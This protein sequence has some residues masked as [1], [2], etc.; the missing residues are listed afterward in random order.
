MNPSAFFPEPADFRIAS[1]AR[2]AELAADFS[3]PVGEYETARAA[4]GLFDRSDRGIAIV[5]GADRATWLH[6]LLSNA[7]KTV[8]VNE[9]VYAFALDVRGRIR[10]DA[11]VLILPDEIWLDLD[12]GALPAALEHL[13]KFLIM[14]KAEITDASL[15]FA[16]LGV[17]GPR[18]G[19]IAT[20]IGAPNFGALP[21]LHGVWIEKGATRLIRHDFAG[22]PGFE[23]IF[24]RGVAARWWSRLAGE[25]NVRPV[26]FDVLD[27]LR[28]E[29][30]IP[31]LG[32]DMDEKTVA[33]ET[34]QIERAISY[35]KGCYLGQEV[36]ERMRSHGSQARRL[37]RLTAED[38]AGIAIPAALY[39]RETDQEVGRVTS[40]VRHPVNRS[41]VGLGYLRS[42]L[43]EP[44][45]LMFGGKP[46][47]TEAP[48][49]S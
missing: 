3:D 29:A 43:Q 24:P 21:A 49:F 47:R 23:L 9:G 27:V 6:N 41:W 39:L 30:G 11:N 26:G 46:I 12:L 22:L 42:G 16:R 32:R 18:A 28:I 14:E 37:V 20:A 35:G 10:F 48:G 19:E 7:V 33:P 45:N 38:A 5:R 2:G 44:I 40:L 4:A 17:S 15:N 13:N 8:D 1:L 31:W 34:N 25:L 36:I